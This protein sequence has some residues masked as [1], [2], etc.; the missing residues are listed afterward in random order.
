MDEDSGGPFGRSLH[1]KRQ[2]THLLF[3]KQ[4]WHQKSAALA[5]KPFTFPRNFNAET[6]MQ[7]I[8]FGWLLDIHT[9]FIKVS[10]NNMNSKNDTLAASARL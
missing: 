4:H 10:L 5:L 6:P 2:L 1:G 9:A 8:D 7:L 3:G